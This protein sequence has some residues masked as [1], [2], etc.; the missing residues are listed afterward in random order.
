[1]TN[2]NEALRYIQA[3]AEKKIASKKEVNAAY[4]A[5]HIKQSA[6]HAQYH[7]TMTELLYFIGGATVIVG[8]V[9]S[10]GQNWA[11]LKLGTKLLVTIGSALAAHCLGLFI[12]RNQSSRAI[13]HAFFLIAAVIMPIGLYILIN[14]SG[15]HAQTSGM[16]SIIAGSML[17]LYLLSQ[18]FLKKPIF[19]LLIIFF[20]TWFFLSFSF[21]LL[22]GTPF[23]QTETLG[24]YLLFIVGIV[25]LFLG[26]AFNWHNH[27][28]LSMTLY[29]FGTLF[30]LFSAL[31]LGGWK[32]E[33]NL[34][35]E[36]SCP[37][38]AF[39]ALYLS[40]LIKNKIVLSLGTF[41]LITYLFKV[42]YQYFSSSFGWPVA[43]VCLGLS[44]IL[45]GY[46]PITIKNKYLTHYIQ[47]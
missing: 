25:Y 35:W 32:P 34:F 4:D 43:L 26:H 22:K 21:F 47:K 14:N 6:S 12:G 10:L 1:M 45:I 28:S 11:E 18:L 16:Q 37:L 38:L 41:F 8:I 33:Q 17:S 29:G 42:T 19:T 13:E 20:S 46:F 39:G 27:T 36:I 7:F 9:V 44:I 40:V 5:G 24:C 2:K 23:L 31:L 15:Y 30:A 3:L